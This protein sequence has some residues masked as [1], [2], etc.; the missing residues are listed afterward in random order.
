[1]DTVMYSKLHEPALTLS[2]AV[3]K[4]VH[5]DS[6]FIDCEESGE[7]ISLKE[8]IWMKDAMVYV[9]QSDQNCLASIQM[10]QSTTISETA[11]SCLGGAIDKVWPGMR[12]LFAPA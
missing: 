8:C 11:S 2:D 5:L 3:F 4:I 12:E 7:G 9:L 10:I 6:C 1:M